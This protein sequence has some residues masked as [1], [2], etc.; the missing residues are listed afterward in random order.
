[1]ISKFKFNDFCLLVFFLCHQFFEIAK[2]FRAEWFENSNY[3]NDKTIVINIINNN[4]IFYFKIVPIQ[5]Q[6]LGTAGDPFTILPWRW[7]N[8][9]PSQLNPFG[10][11]FPLTKTEIV[12]KKIIIFLRVAL[13]QIQKGHKIAISQTQLNFES[14]HSLSAKTTI[15]IRTNRCIVFCTSENIKNAPQYKNEKFFQ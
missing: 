9:L 4:K 8:K 15:I 2:F 13:L 6:D 7:K 11:R 14:I 12:T 1:M 3:Y 5:G 10:I